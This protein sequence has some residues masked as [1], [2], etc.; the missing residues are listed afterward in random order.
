MSSSPHSQ[1]VSVN[2]ALKTILAP[3]LHKRKYGALAVLPMQPSQQENAAGIETPGWLIMYTGTTGKQY[4]A[5][6]RY[7]MG[8]GI[9]N[10]DDNFFNKQEGMDAEEVERLIKRLP[11]LIQKQRKRDMADFARTEKANGLKL[12]DVVKKMRRLS[13]TEPYW[14]PTEEELSLFTAYGDLIYS[15]H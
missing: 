1:V 15:V 5:E 6:L 11:G 8:R 14:S 7:D 12:D 4:L 3:Y 10:Y 13:I 9:F 2:N